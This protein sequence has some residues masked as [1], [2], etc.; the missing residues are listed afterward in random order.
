M[1]VN[2]F[3]FLDWELNI[4]LNGGRIINLKKGDDLILGTYERIDGKSGNTHVCIPN[5]A[6]HGVEEFG[7]PFHGPFR[8]G[9]W[10]LIDKKEDSV[11]VKCE[12]EQLSVVQ[13]FIFDKNS[14]THK[15]TIEN[16]GN[17]PKPVNAA[18]HNYWSSAIGWEGV[19]LNGNNLSKDIKESNFVS[20][21]KI[22][23]LFIPGK[24]LIR[25]SLERLNHAKLWTGFLEEGGNKIFDNNYFCLEP[26][27]EKDNLFFGSPASMINSGSK[28]E[29]EQKIEIIGE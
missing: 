10:S 17:N 12:I 24:P 22:N 5:F 6:D 7:L 14:L 1:Q 3:S 29:I 28:I 20:L 11:S 26:I 13:L 15:I 25:W 21:E 4:D 27:M 2:Q 8:N 9:S 18:I 16:V 23:E 19:V